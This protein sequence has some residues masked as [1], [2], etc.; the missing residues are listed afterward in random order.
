MRTIDEVTKDIVDREALIGVGITGWMNNPDILF[1]KE[2]Q[3]KGAAVVK[4][5][6][7]ITADIIGINQ[8]ARTTVVKPLT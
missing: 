1:D 8:A 3:Q 2:I 5:W 7:K 6:N 4:K